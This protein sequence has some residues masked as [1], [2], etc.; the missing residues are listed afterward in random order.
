MIAASL[1][2]TLGTAACSQAPLGTT[3]PITVQT[4]GQGLHASKCTLNSSGTQATATGTFSPPYA[5]PIDAFGQQE[6]RNLQLAVM[7]PHKGVNGSDMSDGGSEAGIS[8]G[9]TSWRLV[10]TVDGAFRPTRC[11]VDLVPF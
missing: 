2:V 9:E 3:L 4:G 1:L 11:I 8:V 5:L 7:T 6:S 10:A